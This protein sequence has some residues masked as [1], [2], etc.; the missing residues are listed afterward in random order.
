MSNI[1]IRNKS[2]IQISKG[3]K[4]NN[5]VIGANYIVLEIEIFVI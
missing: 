2:K 1:E 3:S 4:P 5:P